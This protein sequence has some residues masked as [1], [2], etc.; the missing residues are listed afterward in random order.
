[1]EDINLT[2]YQSWKLKQQ[3]RLGEQNKDEIVELSRGEDSATIK[4]RQR[5]TELLERSKKTLEES[6]SISGWET[7]SC[8]SG[9]TVPLSAFWTGAGVTGPPTIINDDNFSMLSGRSS[10][11]SQT[12][13]T[14]SQ[15]M[16]LPQAMAQVPIVPVSTVQGPSGEQIVNL[17]S[18]QSWIANVVT[19]T[20]IQ[21]QGEINLPPSR[22]GSV[23]SFDRRSS[24]FS[25]QC[26][27]DDKTSVL[28]GA[29]YSSL[30]SHGKGRAESVISTGGASNLTDMS[31]LGS[32]RNKITTTS[33]PLYS[34]FQDQVN[35]RKLD[36]MDKEIKSE[37]REKMATYA[38]KKITEDNKRS[39]L[40]KKKKLKEEEDQEQKKADNLV[41]TSN[42]KK[43]TRSYGLSG[44]LNLSTVLERDKNTSIDEW[45]DSVR[46]PQRK[47]ASTS[48]DRTVPVS[49]N[50]S[51]S[52]DQEFTDYD[53]PIRR[54][55]Y[56]TEEQDESNITS[57]YQFKFQAD[58][59]SSPDSS[60][61]P[62]YPRRSPLDTEIYS[63]V[64]KESNTYI[65]AG[66][67]NAPLEE[68]GEVSKHEYS[69]KKVTNYSQYKTEETQ[70][71]GGREE[72]EEEYDVAAFISQT[73]QRSR[74][75]AAAE[76]EN[77]K[78]IAA[79]RE[80]QVTKSESYK[81]SES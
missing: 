7:E 44:R 43:S 19:E 33:V 6:Q 64:F 37:M 54:A 11:I 77:D 16:G 60:P 65:R 38:V 28:S 67:S 76:I 63:N 75:Q 35:M 50:T 3:K 27:N 58:R 4:R 24:I 51:R 73:R 41:D 17:A 29:S 2:A 59:E 13:S 34:L 49:S 1:M 52:A 12:R 8:F 15:P 71:R 61:E 25:G 70:G 80:Q 40:Y 69:T 78:V 57:R 14:R 36:S 68:Y 32:R 30:Q 66:A 5:R 26:M 22:S 46:P 55:S 56:T 79:W 20:L 10:V 9:G 39:T 18:I 72:R 53:L 62:Y 81:S 23:L 45:L 21:K 31:G 47:Q 48:A 74:V 42:R